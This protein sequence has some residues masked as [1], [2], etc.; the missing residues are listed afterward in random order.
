MIEKCDIVDTGRQA[1]RLVDAISLLGLRT[2]V[3]RSKTHKVRAYCSNEFFKLDVEDSAKFL[4]EYEFGLSSSISCSVGYS[5]PFEIEIKGDKREL[6]SQSL[7]GQNQSIRLGTGK[8]S[9]TK[10]R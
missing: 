6:K 9:K 7:L 10:K 4:L 2:V 1:S 3:G 8:G 5:Y